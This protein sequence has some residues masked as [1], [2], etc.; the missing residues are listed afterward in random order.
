M[1]TFGGLGGL[2]AAA[3][4]QENAKDF[5]LPGQ[6]T[7]G[8]SDLHWSPR[9]DMLAAASWDNQ[10]RIWDVNVQ[11]SQ[12]IPRTMFNLDG[13]ALS[14]RWTSD[15]SKVVAAG[16]DKTAKLFDLQSNQA[17]QVAAHDAPIRFVRWFE[18]NNNRVLITGSWDK[19]IKYWDLRSPTPVGTVNVGERVYAMD[20]Y[21]NLLVVGTADRKI[22]VI[23][24]TT[25]GNI[26]KTIES[27]LKWQ[28]RTVACFPSGTGFALGSIEGRVGIQ[29]IDDKNKADNFSF[30]CHRDSA[31]PP[32]VYAVNCIAVHPGY[33]TFATCGSDGAFHFWDKDART[34]LKM[35]T[36]AGKG[37]PISAAAFSAQGNAFA[38][39]VSYDWSKGH[40]HYQQGAANAIKIHA[41]QD[42]DIKNRPKK[43]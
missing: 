16:A 17:V 43:R 23:N 33:G 1:A 15:G 22:H 39:A 10:V 14:C 5:E 12:A 2:G 7:D 40:E 29:Y 32:N 24:L 37:V 3:P 19:T 42:A 27:P 20:A 25:P 21:G 8:I 11:T 9:A 30:K 31:Q 38:Y 18:E 26:F 4:G 13:P 34:R 36:N 6:L 41:V 28:L 35:F